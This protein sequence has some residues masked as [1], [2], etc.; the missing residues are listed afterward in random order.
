M[1]KK[2]NLIE[3]VEDNKQSNEYLSQIYSEARRPFTS[4]PFKLRDYL[5]EEIIKLKT[6]KFLDVGCGRGDI[7]KAFNELDFRCEGVDLSREAKKLCSPVKVSQ[8]NLENN[9]IL[10]LP[11]DFDI[12]F[13][14]SLIEHL[15]NPLGFLRSCK[16]LIKENGLS[17]IHI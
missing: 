9:E 5:I 14:K 1:E 15:H 6:G 8:V 10:V 16:K 4:Y 3:D 2:T 7:L 11:K 17:L 13:S 12:I